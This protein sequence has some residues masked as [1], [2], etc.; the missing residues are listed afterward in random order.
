MDDADLERAIGA[1]LARL[2]DPHAPPT[3]LPRVL[4]AVARY[5]QRPWYT[6]AW[7]TWPAAWQ[8]V[9]LGALAAVV[10]A[11]AMVVPMARVTVAH[12]L[13]VNATPAITDVTLAAQP[14]ADAALRAESV[15]SAL[16]SVW[17]AVFAPA[18]LYAA[19]LL[20]LMFF[21]C[22]AFAAALVHLT[23]EKVLP[24]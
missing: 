22:A 14:I 20:A 16:R 2:P 24:R 4:A 13:S 15:T 18:T 17:A 5:A 9:S 11:A 23:S 12:A 19:A 10:A 1:A 8:A 7:L 21:S 6:R 3:L